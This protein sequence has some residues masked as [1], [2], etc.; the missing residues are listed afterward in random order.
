MR[1]LGVIKPVHIGETGWASSCNGFYGLSGSKATDEYK[2]SIYYHAIRRWTEAEGISCFFFEAFD[3][4][5][6]DAGNPGGSENHFG[7]FTV[8][9]KAKYI[10]W[11][12]VDMNKLNKPGRNRKTVLKTFD[13]D[14]NKLLLDVALPPER[15]LKDNKDKVPE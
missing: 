14:V 9:G 13:G 3:E 4:I 15:W 12:D 6:K 10:L 5:W 2:Q 7:L 1:S 8:D 11:E